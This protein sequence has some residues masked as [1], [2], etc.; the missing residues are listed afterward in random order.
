MIESLEQVKES[1][2][3]YIGREQKEIEIDERKLTEKKQRCSRAKAS[4]AALEGTA[5]R[6]ALAKLKSAKPCATKLELGEIIK[7]ILTE[8]ST[9]PKDDLAALAKDKLCQQGK[10]L[11]GFGLRFREVLT[12]PCIAEVQPGVYRWIES[13]SLQVSTHR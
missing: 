10:S 1:L 6:E 5:P 8:N 2:L 12:D 13:A 9:V 4:L 7:K 3:A 11:N